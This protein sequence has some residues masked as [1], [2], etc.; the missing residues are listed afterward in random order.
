VGPVANLVALR[1]Q[2]GGNPP[3]RTLLGDV[4]RTLR[5]AREHQEMPFD[6][7]VL[8]LK[9]EKDMSRTALFD[10]LFHY[11]DTPAPEFDCGGG[12]T[13]RL[14]DSNLGHGKYDL[15]LAL[16]ATAEGGVAGVLVY[17]ADLH[18]A[19]FMAQLLAHFTRVVAAITADPSVRVDD[20]VLLDATEERRQLEEWNATPAAA[21]RDRTLHALF[22]AQVA[23]TPDRIALS[24]DRDRLSYVELDARA[25]RLA[26]HLR[27]QGVGP[28][29]LVAVCLDRSLDLIAALLAVLK[30]GGAYLPLDPA[31]PRAR[32]AFTVRDAEV[33][34]LVTTTA[35][36]ACITEPVTHVT[37]LDAEAAT[38]AA[39]PA[40]A[41]A[42]LAGPGHLAY[43]LYTS[44]S[45]G[46]PKGVLLE[47]RQVTRLLI[48]DRLPF[49]FGP[50]DVWTLFHSCCFDFSVWEMFGALLYGG[51]LVVVPRAVAQD[52]AAFLQLV[53][54]ERVTVLNQ[55][56]TSFYNFAREALR[57]GPVLALRYVVF[58]GEA[59]LPR[60]LR[61]FARTY[62][63]VKLVNMYGI[64]ETTVHV[65]WTEVS[66]EDMAENRSNIGGPIPTTTTY[67]MD[68]QLRLVPVGVPGEICVGGEG[69]G[70]GY[71]RRDELT[72]QRFV[73]N[74]YRPAERLYRS[75]DL[76]R[77]QPD[78]RMI[79]LGRI[80][81]QVQIRGFRVEL[82]EIKTR[83]LE[84]PGVRDVEVIARPLHTDA[85]ELVAY[86]VPRGEVSTTELRRH[87]VEKLP[88]YM[89]PAALVLLA[90][91]PLTANGKVDRR[92]LPEP[93]ALPAGDGAD[94]AAPRSPTEEKLAALYAAVLRRDRVGVD[95]SFFDLGGHSLLATQLVSRIRETFGLELP[96]RQVF[97]APTVGGLAA[98]I[99]AR[100]SAGEPAATAPAITRAARRPRREALAS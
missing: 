11:D 52:P 86:L 94:Y 23:R 95:H 35:L 19:W 18:D 72:Q 27:A 77:Q 50:D 45:T 37:R 82:G 59:L 71:L 43:C 28:D 81:D 61:E 16:R 30:A 36:A 74:P 38:L 85:L 29:T 66:E 91:L 60:H 39:A 4:T 44:G 54:R 64:T 57:H 90:A 87:L 100:R 76:A 46:Q 83:L 79:Y 93:E 88:D 99:E 12:V 53:A 78:G 17:N 70:R 41:P 3:F 58:G 75:G 42:D 5:D 47:H 22:A 49:A 7:L 65:T 15:N 24:L 62:P 55:T 21:P 34:H 73:R 33:R 68:S 32:L 6:P 10:V 51:R 26:H 84:H 63:A 67:L 1:H 56:P 2:L 20:L 96:L 80:D 48:N 13:A 92:A 25:N 69:V 40:I 98:V 8:A 97:E 89:V 31:Y 9:P 14:I